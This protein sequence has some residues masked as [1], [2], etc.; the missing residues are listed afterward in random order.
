MLT[1]CNYE[2]LPPDYLKQTNKPT[3]NNPYAWVGE[4]HNW[5]MDRFDS[6]EVDFS[7]QNSFE[8]TK[9]FMRNR[10]MDVNDF[11]YRRVMEK[12]GEL[13]K[14]SFPGFPDSIDHSKSDMSLEEI[15]HHLYNQRQIGDNTKIN[16]LEMVRIIESYSDAREKLADYCNN[17]NGS[18]D[19]TTKLII[20][21]S[22][23]IYRSSY[24]WWSSKFVKVNKITVPLLVK[25]DVGGAIIGGGA[26]AGYCL[27][28]PTCRFNYRELLGSAIG[29]G[30]AASFVRKIGWQ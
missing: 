19:D 10:G 9:Q 8:L 4:G 28:S 1:K 26:Y 30:A 23:S 12:T 29:T 17:L 18:V 14:I 13:L 27:L 7:L 15:V 6:K 16:L 11:D 25:V 24:E 5:I 2:N 3:F 21:V 20:Y 22:E